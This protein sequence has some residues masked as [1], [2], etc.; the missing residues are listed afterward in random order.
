MR[1]PIARGTIRTSLVLGLRLAVQAG[2]LLLVARM[3]GPRQFGVFAG[4]AA[5]AV[6]LGTLSTFG[7]N[8]VLLG[9]ISRSP[10]RRERILPYAIPC[11]LLC[12]GLLLV[13]YLL[14]C[15]WLLDALRVPLGAVLLV[16][17]TELLLQPL[18]T[19][20]VAEHHALGRIARSQL[21]QMMPLVLR[22]LVAVLIA[23]FS[24]DTPLVAYASGYMA[25]SVLALIFGAFTLPAPW[26]SWRNWRRPESRE[27][28]EAFGYAA[29]SITRTG[30][31]ELDKTLALHLLPAGAAGIYSAAAR[32]I[33]GMFV[34]ITAMTLS[35]LPRLFR[36]V[37]SA[38]GRH[39]LAWMFG[40]AFVY[41]LCL[42]ALLWFAAPLFS[43]VFGPGYGEV[44]GMIR[45]LIP[46]LPGLALRL[47]AGNALITM[48]MP[49]ARVGFEV[50]G[51]ITLV[52]ASLA[53]A[54]RI[55]ISGMPLAVACAEWAM[56]L[57]GIVLVL[58]ARGNPAL[59]S[60]D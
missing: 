34:P 21:L 33:G 51:I 31:A 52:V 12:G 15:L 39:L 55:G 54:D 35:A 41:S 57:I 4:I 32:V 49:W 60:R 59:H 23:V 26:P 37:H 7:T 45:W 56:A 29:S 43:H 30:P 38:G 14:V 3:L 24:P 25:A 10:Q 47:V 40:V 19:L 1:G 5:L 13:F 22:L 17:S 8:L 42:A 18:L 9:E 58:R 53:L 11:T 36:N 6:L 27:W 46:A 48:G 50:V 20:M 28:R 2:T 44:G 16:G